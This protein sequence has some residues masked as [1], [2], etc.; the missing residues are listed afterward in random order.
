MR[1]SSRSRTSPSSPA[2]R[3]L[4][5]ATGNGTSTLRSPASSRSSKEGRETRSASP[6][7]NQRMAMEAREMNVDPEPHSSGPLRPALSKIGQNIDVTKS[8][9]SSTSSPLKRSDGIMNLDQASLGSPVAK[10][11]S[12]HGATFD[13]DFNIFEHGFPSPQSKPSGDEAGDRADPASSSNQASGSSPFSSNMPKRSSSLRKSTLQQRHEK[14]TFARTRPNTDLAF[15]LASHGGAASRQK[16]HRMSLES[17]LPPM[18][19]DSP[20]SA[21]GNLASASVHVLPQNNNQLNHNRHPLSQTLSQSSSGSS[22]IED[23]PTHFAMHHNDYTRT[24]LDFSKSLPVGAARP[25]SR[26]PATKESSTQT[27]SAESFVTPQSYKLVKPLPAA[28]M[29]TGLISKRNRQDDGDLHDVRAKANMP[30]TPCKRPAMIFATSPAPAAPRSFGQSR[31]IR[32]EFGT[33]STPFNPH[34]SAPAPATFGK[35]VGV[36][37]SSFP[38]GS[39][40]RRDSFLSTGSDDNVQSPSN[41]ADHQRVDFPP[42]PT[43]QLLESDLEGSPVTETGNSS[44]LNQGVSRRVIPSPISAAKVQGAKDAHPGKL[45]QSGTPTGSVSGDSDGTAEESPS[46]RAKLLF[47]HAKPLPSSAHSHSS[48]KP[49]RT[50]PTSPIEKSLS[51]PTVTASPNRLNY[52]ELSRLSSASPSGKFSFERLSPCTPNEGVL[53]PDPSGLSIS[54][55]GTGAKTRSERTARS[56]S[57][58]FPPATPTAPRE[59]FPA[60]KDKTPSV[61]PINGFTSTD[62]DLSLSA[63]FDKVELIGIGEFSQVFRVTEAARSKSS[64]S[65]FS[66]LLQSSTRSSPS[67]PLPG[68]VFAVKKSRQTYFGAKDRERRMQEVHVLRALGQADHIIQLVDSWENH[69]RLYIQTEFCEEGSLDLFLAAVGRKARLDDFRIWKILLELSLG[70]RHIH[71][72]GFIHLDLKPANVLITFEGVLKIADFGMATQWPAQP[73]IEGEGDR[74]YI[75]P[76][77]LMGKFDKPADIFAL[78]LIMLEI[79]GNVELPDNGPS[80][81]KLRTGDMSDVP[82]LTWSSGS[83]I[84]RDSSGNPVSS[85]E[86][87]EELYASDSGDDDFASS[88]SLHLKDGRPNI[89][90]S[91]HTS[92][93]RHGE[94]VQPPGFMMDPSHE[95]A[96]DMVVRWMISPNPSDRPTVDQIPE[97][98]GVRWAENRRRAGATVFEGNWGPADDVL[99]EDSEMIDV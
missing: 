38:R 96:L 35:G 10:R 9:R 18:P 78:G 58:M 21:Q 81:Q 84:F 95:Q 69:N 20:F 56:G 59:Y 46:T 71:Q 92:L 72:S 97:T 77:I 1:A 51:A 19:R 70:V 94:L 42:T 66:R 36:F 16:L 99:G 73:G 44:P 74:E 79:A 55:H 67:T 40:S 24:T 76:E 28:F 26:K 52:A 4:G 30:D 63:R 37:G 50:S 87:L 31:Q 5:L 68:R 93:A 22:L 53:P 45:S 41:R 7:E 8:T 98:L 86:S 3:P 54:G 6:S 2:R 85:D 25:A 64:T 80:W 39:I 65:Y 49:P 23:S 48:R 60:A 82:S 29:S 43:K 75:G 83:R 11:R 89:F 88:K 27:S 17:F 61:T 15:E 47:A 62:V 91:P 34:S 33:P 14:P 13:A 57:S 12:L 90:T 32:H